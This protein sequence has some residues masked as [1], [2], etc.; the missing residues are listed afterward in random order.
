MKTLISII[1]A[2]AFAAAFTAPM[3]AADNHKADKEECQT[4]HMKWN[5]EASKCEAGTGQPSK[6]SGTENQSVPRE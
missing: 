6:E 3:F 2:L 5:Q 1:V 4:K